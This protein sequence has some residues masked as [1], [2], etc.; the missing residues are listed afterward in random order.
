MKVIMDYKID[1]LWQSTVLAIYFLTNT[2][3]K[4]IQIQHSNNEFPI[5]VFDY[6]IRV[7]HE[8]KTQQNI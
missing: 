7:V 8:S 5:V 3:S 4:Y 2:Y 1:T 6:H